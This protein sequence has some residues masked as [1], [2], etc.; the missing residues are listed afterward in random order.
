MYASRADEAEK[1]IS[2]KKKTKQRKGK[3]IYIRPRRIPFLK[4]DPPAV[5]SKPKSKYFPN[6]PASVR[7]P[8]APDFLP[9]SCEDEDDERREGAC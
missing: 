3:E 9:C 7:N 2:K 4:L 6:L 5:R 8:K 1:R